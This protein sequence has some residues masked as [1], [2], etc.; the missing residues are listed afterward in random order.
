MSNVPVSKAP[1]DQRKDPKEY[2]PFLRELKALDKWEQR[3]RIDDHLGRRESALMNLRASGMSW[4]HIP[5]QVFTFT[6]PERFEEASSYLARYELYDAAFRLYKD[7]P[8]HL[9]VRLVSRRFDCAYARRRFKISTATTY[10]TV[11][12]FT[13]PP[14]LIHWLATRQ[15]R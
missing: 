1:T 2:L 6:G 15:R 13:S 11:E 14:C 7:E 3:F 5:E 9:T 12:T 8:E 4:N 10:M